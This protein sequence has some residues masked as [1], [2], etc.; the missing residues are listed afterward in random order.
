[1]DGTRMVREALH[2]VNQYRSSKLVIKLGEAIIR[3]PKALLEV[4]TDIN[5]LK[6]AEIEVFIAHSQREL[7]GDRLFGNIPVLSFEETENTSAD[8][9]I[10]EFAISLKAKK[11]V[12][13]TE[14][15]GIFSESKLI[16]QVTVKQAQ[17][18]LEVTGLITGGMRNKLGAAIVA[19][20]AGVSRVHII[21]GLREGSLLKE[22][23]SCEGLGTMI[24]R[25]ASY[26]R[27]RR[28][29]EGDILEIAKV[30]SEQGFSA[31]IALEEIIENLERI[32]VFTVDGEVHGCAITTEHET[33]SAVEVNYLSVS[34]SYEDSDA[35]LK[36]LRKIIKDAR[37]REIRY[38]LLDTSKN[39]AL[40]GIY[41]WFLELG[42]KQYNGNRFPW[43]GK[44]V[45]AKKA[46]V[47]YV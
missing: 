27:A 33:T 19:C 30:L 4:I 43:S 28:A 22:I 7:T 17:E 44:E 45:Q 34:S 14:R 18:L 13:V 11:L 31:S 6:A 47:K 25:R 2:F 23:L 9:L 3:Q 29:K 8:A 1:M 35:L 39:P 5:L 36:L 42:F 24:Y 26:Q 46:W 32:S 21:S 37:K 20:K 10:A 40:L 38:V 15:D 41:P 12:Y 16:R